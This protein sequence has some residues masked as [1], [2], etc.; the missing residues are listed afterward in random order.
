MIFFALYPVVVSDKV[1]DDEVGSPIDV[2]EYL[3]QGQTFSANW[4]DI[5]LFGRA[6]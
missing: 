6:C 5:D 1:E 3:W 2:K 4:Q